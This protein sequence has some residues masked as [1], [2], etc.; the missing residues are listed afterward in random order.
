MS[1]DFA[2]I[3][4]LAG[5]LLQSLSAPERRSLL[6]KM[7]RALRATQSER[8]GRQQ[9]PDGSAY[10]SRRQRHEQ[11]VGKRAVKFLYPKGDAN[12]RLVFMKSW[13]RQGP[14]L[15]GF[16]A[17]AGAMRSFFWDKVDR[18]LPVEPEDQNRNAGKLRRRGNIRR[19]AMFRKLRASRFLR[20][21]VTDSEAWI[22]FTGR[23]SSIASVHQYGEADTPKKGGKEVRYPRR[24]LIG[25]T[26]RERGM[27]IDML[28]DHVA[29]R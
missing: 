9:N 10:A 3:E 12:P 2:P 8:I 28:L 23:A 29:A 22:G 4:Q 26:E 24:T 18:F 21:G 17:E 13:V 1:E 27:A 6:R 16:D 15:T 14:L 19:Q 7:A 5:N 25:L 11:Q 20:A